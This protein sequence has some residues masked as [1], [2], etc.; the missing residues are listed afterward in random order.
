MHAPSDTQKLLDCLR[1]AEKRAQVLSAVLLGGQPD[2]VA[3]AAHDVQQSALALSES[4]QGAQKRGALEPVLKQRLRRLGQELAMQREACMRRSAVVD[5][6][7]NSIIPSSRP[8][9]Y[10]ARTGPYG[11]QARRSGAFNLISA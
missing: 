4:L 1:I 11:Q 2:L 6:A 3:A 5:R 10:S 7:L 9:T 8:N